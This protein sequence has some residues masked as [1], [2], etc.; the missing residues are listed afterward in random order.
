MI[1]H[2]MLAAILSAMPAHAVARAQADPSLQ[3]RIVA[4][5]TDREARAPDETAAASPDR[6]A[7]AT[8]QERLVAAMLGK[9]A[10]DDAVFIAPATGDIDIQAAIVATITNKD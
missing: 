10:A 5:L 8:Y 7:N 4:S 9:R 6:H 2:L 3:D 1:K